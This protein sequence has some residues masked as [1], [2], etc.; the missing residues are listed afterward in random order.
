MIKLLQQSCL[1]SLMVC[2]SAVA[3]GAD[4]PLSLRAKPSSAELAPREAER[5]QVVL[6]AL[7]ATV[8]AGVACAAGATP[9]SLMVSIS[10]SYRHFGPEL[11]AENTTLEAAFELPSSQLAPV[12][13]AGF[14]VAEEAEGDQ[15]L[16]LPAI[17]TAQASLRCQGD[18]AAISMHFESLPI[19]VSLYCRAAGEPDSPSP[20]R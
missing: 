16:E 7:D 18:D 4:N 17:A 20:D 11:L 2:A 9:V 10:D 14:C 3:V 5:H 1:L 6:P 12:S 8:V 15:V 19:P 13:L